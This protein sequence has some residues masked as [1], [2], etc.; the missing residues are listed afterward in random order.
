MKWIIHPV[1]CYTVS[2]KLSENTLGNLADFFVDRLEVLRQQL[3]DLKERFS[4][5]SQGKLTVQQ[6]ANETDAQLSAQE[7][8]YEALTKQL[9][10]LRDTRFKVIQV[11][12]DKTQ[13]TNF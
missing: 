6:L 8:N 1:F 4:Y 5:V 3:G 7:S 13:M 11:N 2:H 10:Q 9:Q 12:V